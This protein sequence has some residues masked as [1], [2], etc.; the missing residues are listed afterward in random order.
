MGP[1]L[2]G[3]LKYKSNADPGLC[4]R[5]PRRGPHPAPQQRVDGGGAPPPA[6]GAWTTGPAHTYVWTAFGAASLPT[7]LSPPTL[8]K[9]LLKS[10][11]NPPSLK[12][13]GAGGPSRGRAGRLGGRGATP[14]PGCEGRSP[15]PWSRPRRRA[16]RRGGRRWRL[17]FIHGPPGGAL[18]IPLREIAALRILRGNFKRLCKSMT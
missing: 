1:S 11:F 14:A 7:P 18:N 5:S 4:P 13:N 9:K 12:T 17:L 6:L 15:P 3:R 2:A 16:G 8:L 10:P